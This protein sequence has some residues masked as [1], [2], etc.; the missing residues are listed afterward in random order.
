MIGA[1]TEPIES[2]CIST[3]PG[4]SSISISINIVV[5]VIIA[6]VSIIIMQQWCV[7][8]STCAEVAGSGGSLGPGCWWDSDND[9]LERPVK[10]V[11][12]LLEFLL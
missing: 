2:T 12:S 5:V 7:D 6:K 10:S 3:N 8:I 9:K 4:M 11:G 1:N